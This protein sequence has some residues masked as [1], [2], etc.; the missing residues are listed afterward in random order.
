M[1]GQGRRVAD[2]YQLH[3]CPGH[4]HVH[5]PQVPEET[6]VPL[7]VAPDHGYDYDVAFLSLKPIDRIY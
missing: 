5:A 6:Y 4:C 7:I 3:P 1:G 2:Y